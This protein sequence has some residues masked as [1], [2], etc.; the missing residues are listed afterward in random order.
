MNGE[1]A[2]SIDLRAEI[3]KRAGMVPTLD[4]AEEGAWDLSHDGLA[5]TLGDEWKDQ[6]RHVAA[7][8]RW[9][10]WDGELWKD[11]KRLEHMTRTRAFLR[12]LAAQLPEKMKDAAKKLRNAETVAKVVSLARS[13]V[14][15]AASVDQWDADPYQVGH[16]NAESKP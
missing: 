15:Q 5:L 16:P 3:R 10:F 12:E 6:A 7:W 14:A 1:P 8:G 9:L 4:G 2:E 13:N 11:D